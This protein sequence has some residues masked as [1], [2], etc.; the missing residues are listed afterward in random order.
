MVLTRTE[1]FVSLKQKQKMM[2]LME[3]FLNMN[4]LFSMFGENVDIDSINKGP[5]AML[6]YIRL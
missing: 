5:K 4:S 2:V 3:I 6:L 1:I